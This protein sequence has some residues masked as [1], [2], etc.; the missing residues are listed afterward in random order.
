MSGHDAR[1]VVALGAVQARPEL[2]DPAILV[3]GITSPRSAF[4]QYQALA[5]AAIV[6][7]RLG[8]A[9]REQRPAAVTAARG[10]G[11]FAPGADRDDVAASALDELQR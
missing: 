9:A 7:R 1:R 5:A 6:A 2:A 4:E 11:A 10:S 8:G 3:E